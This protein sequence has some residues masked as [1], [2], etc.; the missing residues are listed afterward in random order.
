MILSLWA[1]KVWCLMIVPSLFRTHPVMVSL[2]M[3][4]PQYIFSIFFFTSLGAYSG[5]KH[6]K[7]HEKKF[8]YHHGLESPLRIVYIFSVRKETQKFLNG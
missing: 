3:S 4:I 8:Y 5:N 6:F 1:G 7:L 2:W